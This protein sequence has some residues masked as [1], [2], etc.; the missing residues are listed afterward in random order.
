[1]TDRN[2][3]AGG[4]LIAMGSIVGTL[5]GGIFGQP[6]AGLLAGFGAGIVGAVIVWLR[7]R[8]VRPARKDFF[9]DTR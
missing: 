5:G 4:F 1:M 8:A 6:S 7:D 9:T 3:H 2:T